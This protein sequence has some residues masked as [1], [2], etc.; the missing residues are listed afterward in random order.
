MFL[1]GVSIKK[2][3]GRRFF[4]LFNNSYCMLSIHIIT[5]P[6][7]YAGALRSN[8]NINETSDID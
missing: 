8:I 3:A 1:V 5:F 2:R 4:L 6:Q 7:G